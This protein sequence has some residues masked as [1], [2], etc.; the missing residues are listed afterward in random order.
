MDENLSAALV[1]AIRNHDTKAFE[2]LINSG[3]ID[4]NTVD[5]DGNTL[6]H[7]AAEE[8]RQD[9]C[10]LLI[11]KGADP[12]ATDWEGTRPCGVAR[13][14]GQPDLGSYLQAAADG[15]LAAAES[16]AE[17][18]FALANKWY[19]K[20]GGWDDDLTVDENIQE[21][22]LQAVLRGRIDDAKELIADG[23]LPK[24]ADASGRMAL[25]L[26]AEN[27]NA[28]MCFLLVGEGADVNAKTKDGSTPLHCAARTGKA[29]NCAN[30]IEIG[31]N[32]EAKDCEGRTA[33]DVAKD[34]GFQDVVIAL[35]SKPICEK[36]EREIAPG[37]GAVEESSVK[38]GRTDGPL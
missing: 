33:M 20:C 18:D 14:V 5:E 16:V 15:G 35:E 7:L 9:F 4:L 21:C 8:G 1:A 24:S 27:G 36:M 12:N 30:L 26:A 13:R 29:D 28:A 17:R 2:R 37:K 6:L 34:K 19:R 31:A 11:S 3:A 38:R 10:K 25:H 22:F 23:A 32:I